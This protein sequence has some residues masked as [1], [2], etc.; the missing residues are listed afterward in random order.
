MTRLTR[1]IWDWDLAQMW[2]T[3]V[4]DPTQGRTPAVSTIFTILRIAITLV[5][6]TPV[7]G[8]V[9]AR[10]IVDDAGNHS[11]VGLVYTW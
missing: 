3:I 4:E 5:R 7:R 8:P 6:P 1:R 10:H 2:M 11:G 9:T